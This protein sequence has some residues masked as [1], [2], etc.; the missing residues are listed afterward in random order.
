MGG[1]KKGSTAR[2]PRRAGAPLPDFI[3]P[4][5]ATLVERAPEGDAWLHEVKLDRDRTGARIIMLT[6][7]M[8][9]TVVSWSALPSGVGSSMLP[10]P[11]DLLRLQQMSADTVE[12][13]EAAIEGAH[14]QI[15]RVDRILRVLDER[16]ARSILSHPVLSG[17]SSGQGQKPGRPDQALD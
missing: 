10:T 5:L 17:M 4:E 15:D 1:V 16:R 7:A 11:A 6:R 2:R 12:R 3:E 8:L 13:A 9:A 14:L